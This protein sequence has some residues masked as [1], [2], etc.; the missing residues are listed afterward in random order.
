VSAYRR[1]HGWTLEELTLFD[2]VRDAEVA[3]D[4]LVEVLE[5]QAK[6]NEK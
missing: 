1:A 6:E 4:R 3:L 5:A 2:A